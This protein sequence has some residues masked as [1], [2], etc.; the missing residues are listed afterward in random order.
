MVSFPLLERYLRGKSGIPEGEDLNGASFEKSLRAL[1]PEIS[2]RER[3]FWT[4]YRHGLLHQVTF[5]TARKRKKD[6]TWHPL[7]GAGISG[8]DDRP[9]YFEATTNE[10]FLNPIV[11]HKLVTET[12]LNDFPTYENASCTYNQL[13]QAWPTSAGQ[14][15]IV[16]QTLSPSFENGPMPTINLSLLKSK[17]GE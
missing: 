5:P 7:P 2:G 8:W 4:C 6:A 16:T 10:F 1:L 12:I 3:A 11:F 17:K 9:V 15:T 13:P 14:A